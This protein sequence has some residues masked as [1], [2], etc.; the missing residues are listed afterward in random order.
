[1]ARLHRRWRCTTV[2]CAALTV[3]LAACGEDSSG[4]STG[5]DVPTS[6][7]S[8][9]G[10]LVPQE[11]R[12][13]G[14]LTVGTDASYPPNE[15][16]DDETIVGLD[17]DLFDAVARE[18]NLETNYESTEFASI[19]TE[20]NKGNYDVGVSSFTINEQR[21]LEANMVSYFDAG[22]QWAAQAGRADAVEP[23][24]PCGLTVAVQVNT[25]QDQQDLQPRA[26]ACRAEGDEP[27]VIQ[28]YEGQDEAT[29]ALTSGAVDA[30][31]ADSP[32][33]SFAV[34]QSEGEIEPVGEVYDAAPYGYVIPIENPELA[35][36]IQM[37]LTTLADD[38]TYAT[39]LEKWGQSQ[40]AIN[41]FAINP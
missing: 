22:T 1:M 10:R 17:I 5:S 39:V 30:M 32:V 4:S 16:L 35:D 3:S 38:G 18:L 11:I 20:T 26:E 40:G 37:A 29:A 14:T 13:V 2:A 31:V 7:L 8:E 36:A 6:E 9:A 19:I 21:K 24:S 33:I 41:D 15:F 23:S 34:R 27:L 12:D 25:L 28:R